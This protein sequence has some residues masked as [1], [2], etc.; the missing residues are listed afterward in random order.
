MANANTS[1]TFGSSGNTLVAVGNG[2][3]SHD[4]LN[5]QPTKHN[6]FEIRQNGDIYIAD[7]ND[8]TYQNYYEKPMKKLQD[9]LQIK[10]VK[11]TQSAYDALSPNYDSNTLYVIVN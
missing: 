1:N 5:P 10:V 3:A 4:W 7:T 2:W 8:T 9:Y 6:A 11:L